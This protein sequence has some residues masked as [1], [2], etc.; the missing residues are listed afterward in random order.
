MNMH[1]NSIHILKRPFSKG[2]ARLY[3]DSDPPAIIY[4]VK[5][6]K[7]EEKTR[8]R[9]DTNFTRSVNRFV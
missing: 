9:R 8:G 4:R 3:I 5:S 2:G 6:V 7:G 1:F